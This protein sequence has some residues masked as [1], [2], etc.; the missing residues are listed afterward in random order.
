[1]TE[2]RKIRKDYSHII[3]AGFSGTG[4]YHRPVAAP[5]QYTAPIRQPARWACEISDPA[6]YLQIRQNPYGTGGRS[7]DS[8]VWISYALYNVFPYIVQGYIM[9]LSACSRNP[10]SRCCTRHAWWTWL[11]DCWW[12]L[13]YT[14]LGREYFRMTDSVG[15]SVSRWPI[16]RKD[17]LCIP[18]WI[19]IPA[20]CCPRRWWYMRWSVSTGTASTS[21]TVCGWAE[22]LFYAHFL[23]IMLMDIS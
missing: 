13:L 5:G 14:L 16:C 22:V 6:V 1:M 15:C 4:A 17:C 21:G 18:M 10:R 8:G 23:I 11:L 9:R 7:A 19:R 12:Q 20:A 3:S 2:C